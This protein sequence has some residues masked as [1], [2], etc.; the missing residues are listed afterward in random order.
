M[1]YG[2]QNGCGGFGG[3][4]LIFCK[5]CI[6]ARRTMNPQVPPLSQDWHQRLWV[7]S[8]TPRAF[9]ERKMNNKVCFVTIP[10]RLVDHE[11]AVCMFPKAFFQICYLDLG[12]HVI[13]IPTLMPD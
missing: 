5:H 11:H 13:T 9:A 2:Q 8:R 3:A 7:A 1:R 4:F 6:C 12:L 10:C